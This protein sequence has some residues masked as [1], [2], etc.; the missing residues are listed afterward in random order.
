MRISDETP[1]AQNQKEADGKSK[2]MLTFDFYPSRMDEKTNKVEQKFQINYF[3]KTEKGQCLNI[4]LKLN[5]PSQYQL[6]KKEVC[7]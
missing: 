3:S 1:I 2:K 6:N 7:L 4:D 5:I